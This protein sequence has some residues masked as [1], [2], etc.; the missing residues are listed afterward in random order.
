MDDIWSI[1][2][3]SSLIAAVVTVILGIARDILVEKHRF[4]R[5]SEA[6]YIQSQIRLYA[7][8]HFLLR[9]LEVSG[10]VGDVLFGKIVENIRELND[11]IKRSSDLLETRLL[12]TWMFIWKVAEESIKEKEEEKLKVYGK[13]MDDKA[14]EM[15]SIIRDIM[16]NNLI[17]KYCKIVGKTVPTLN[18]TDD[19]DKKITEVA[20]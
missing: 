6:G 11:I 2:G 13:I 10:K 3:L 12:N 19:S 20:K 9:R 14:K 16:N 8:I 4:K 1:I 17:P 15:E 7:Q 18:S 5:K